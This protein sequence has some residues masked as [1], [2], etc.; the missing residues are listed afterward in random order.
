MS[1]AGFPMKRIL[2][3]ALPVAALLLVIAAGPSP[4]AIW[5]ARAA[6]LGTLL[7]ALW[8]LSLAVD[9]HASAGTR[10]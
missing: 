8:R 2:K 4:M 9:E 6:A 1:E 5:V 7:V 3:L 10:G